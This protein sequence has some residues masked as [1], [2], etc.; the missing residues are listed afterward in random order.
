MKALTLWQ[1]W[2]TL[3]AYEVKPFEFRKWLAPKWIWHQRIGIH[4]GARKVKIAEI[5]ELIEAMRLEQGWGTALKPEALDL[6]LELRAHPERIPLSSMLC[7][8]IIGQPVPA[9][10]TV[11]QVYGEKFAGDSDR[12]DDSVFGWPV[13]EIQRL[14]PPLPV[15][16]AQGFWNWEG[17]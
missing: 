15:K 1:H 5:D 12:I 2:A 17:P 4:A 9:A 16:G 10:E 6:L 3:V 11:A 13:T 14:E 7:T 8:A